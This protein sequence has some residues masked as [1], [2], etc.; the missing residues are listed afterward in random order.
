M[1]GR[2]SVCY[3]LLEHMQEF[4]PADWFVT[5]QFSV[6]MQIWTDFNHMDE[7]Q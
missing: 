7:K 3:T 4:E 2:E 5:G 1:Q 6:K